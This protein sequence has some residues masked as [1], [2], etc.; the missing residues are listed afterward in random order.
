MLPFWQILLE[1]IRKKTVKSSKENIIIVNV[2]WP[3]TLCPSWFWV[4]DVNCILVAALSLDNSE[5]LSA[6]RGALK[7]DIQMLTLSGHKREF[8]SEVLTRVEVSVVD[9]GHSQERGE[10]FLT[11]LSQNHF[12]FAHTYTWYYPAQPFAAGLFT[13][14]FALLDEVPTGWLKSR[15][16]YKA[17]GTDKPN[18]HLNWN[19]TEERVAKCHI[20]VVSVDNLLGCIPSIGLKVE[21]K[22]P[23]Y[24]AR[25]GIHSPNN[26]LFLFPPIPA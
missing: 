2:C 3:F 12:T 17:Q 23:K 21:E 18:Y 5:W 24:Y 7:T 1:S 25:L 8:F 13:L 16:C 6:S 11:I 4:L 22:P 15:Y 9:R 10:R 26:S 20:Q 14:Q 19:I